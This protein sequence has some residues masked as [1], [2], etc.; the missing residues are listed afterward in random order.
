MIQYFTSTIHK[1]NKR[2][3][4]NSVQSFEIACKI[5]TVIITV[6]C[7]AIEVSMASSYR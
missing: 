2:E 4:K 3:E 7:L 5:S 1:I 6:K